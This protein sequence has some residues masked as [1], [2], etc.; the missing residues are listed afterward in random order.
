MAKPVPAI[1]AELTVTGEV[2]VEVSTRES[3]L[4]VFTVTL[5]KARLVELTVS[6]GLAAA[7]PV[8]LSVT[9]V[10]L[11]LVELLPTVIFP[12]AAPAEVGLN[13]TWSV[14]DC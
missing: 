8:P 4:A 10:V 7:A 11:P 5:P 1:A 12:V 9:P 13:C 2:P 3:A 6:C 14:T